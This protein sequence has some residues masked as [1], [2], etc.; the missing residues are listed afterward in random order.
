MSKTK[1]WAIMNVVFYILTLVVNYLGAAGIFN[2]MS[3]KAV[4]D[5]YPTLITPA[6]FTF[7]IWGLIYV[8]LLSTLLYFLIQEKKAQVRPLISSVSPIFWLSCLF[9]VGWIISFS[10]EMIGLSLLFI[11]GMVISLSHINGKILAHRKE[12]KFRLPAL[13]F[14]IYAGWVTIATVVNV[15]AFLVQ[16]GWN[17]FGLSENLWTL[18]TLIAALGIVLFIQQ[19]LRSASYPLPIIWAYFGILMAH[20]NPQILNGAHPN[21]QMV[22]VVGMVLLLVMSVVQFI[23]NN[24]CILP[25]E[26]S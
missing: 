19:K 18:I 8:L 3:Q 24:Q 9:N 25:K 16:T 15:A 2:G 21:V 5:K 11:V 6:P 13:S 7:S 12:T 23:R 17:R 4:S 20:R 26:V 1:K 14:S 10:Y 22:L